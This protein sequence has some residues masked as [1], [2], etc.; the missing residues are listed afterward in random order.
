[1]GKEPIGFPTP[2][3]QIQDAMV[4]QLDMLE[5]QGQNWAENVESTREATGVVQKLLQEQMASKSA[6]PEVLAFGVGVIQF[7]VLSG[8]IARLGL[9]MTETHKRLTKVEK[10]VK[11]L[12]RAAK[13]SE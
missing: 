13:C 11:D 8:L 4:E 9:E 1:M 7:F 10:A 12:K 3:R 6:Q 2:A 5:A